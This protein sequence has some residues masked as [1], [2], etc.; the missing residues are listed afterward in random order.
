MLRRYGWRGDEGPPHSAMKPLDQAPMKHVRQ[1][2]RRT[3]A[4]LRKSKQVLCLT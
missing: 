4:H 2:L 3:G 1:V